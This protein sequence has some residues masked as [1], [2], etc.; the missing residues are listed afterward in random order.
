MVLRK[1]I[2]KLQM[3]LWVRARQLSI[4]INDSVIFPE[5]TTEYNH[6]KSLEKQLDAVRRRLAKVEYIAQSRLDRKMLKSNEMN[7]LMVND[8]STVAPPTVLDHVAV[9]AP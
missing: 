1:R 6:I 8:S 9:T 3:T 2:E 4:Q 5:D 7:E